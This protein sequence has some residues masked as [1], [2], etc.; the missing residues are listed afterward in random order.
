MIEVLRAKLAEELE[1]YSWRENLRF[2][3]TPEDTHENWTDII[4]DVIEN[5]LDIRTENIQFQAVHRVLGKVG[6]TNRASPRPI[7]ARF[8][9]RDNRTQSRKEI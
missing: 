2:M 3:N 8:L 7:I 6:D 5:E 9:L 1:T 4:Y